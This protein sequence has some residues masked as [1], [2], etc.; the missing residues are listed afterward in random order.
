MYLDFWSLFAGIW[1]IWQG[2]WGYWK[3]VILYVGSTSLKPSKKAI[4]CLEPRFEP[5]SSMLVEGSIWG[6]VS[7]TNSGEHRATSEVESTQRLGCSS[8]LV[9]HIIIRK[10]TSHSQKGATLEPPG[11]VYR[12]FAWGPKSVGLSRG[13]RRRLPR[14][15]QAGLPST[16]SS[17]RSLQL[18]S[19]FHPPRN[20]EFKHV[21][22]EEAKKVCSSPIGFECL[23]LW[24]TY[25][26]T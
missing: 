9:I 5:S 15:A 2:T 19:V 20:K 3:S 13:I 11:I 4:V 21:H 7:T 12:S 1:G 18:F 25:F 6:L 10:K 8:F 23:L 26:W 14:R 24:C 22:K 16:V 17:L